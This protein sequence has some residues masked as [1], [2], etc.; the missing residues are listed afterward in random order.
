MSN[1]N[2]TGT[3]DLRQD[4][5]L[6]DLFKIDSHA[7]K[8]SLRT[9]TIGKVIASDV[10][11][12]GFDA[13]TQLCTLQVQIPRIIKDTDNP[14]KVIIQPPITLK[15]IPVYFPKTANGWLTFPVNIGDTGEII[16][17][18]RNPNNWYQSGQIVDSVYRGT[19]NLAFGVF[20]P[21]LSD[22]ANRIENF[23]I[24]ATVLE[25]SNFLKLG[26]DAQEFAVLGTQIINKLNELINV[27]NNHIHL[28][29][30]TTSAPG[31][32]IV[33]TVAPTLTTQSP[34]TTS[35]LSQKVQVE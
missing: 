23:D 5:E 21:G 15:N 6:E 11:P 27:F 31:S 26:K 4:P 12:L 24:T 32:P 22:T 1:P 2:Q 34:V 35:I 25:A 16:I 18:D 8:L 30:G 9:A 3:F 20:H 19:H 7:Q 14:G 33:A 29:S 10:Q 17:Q 13:A 28:V